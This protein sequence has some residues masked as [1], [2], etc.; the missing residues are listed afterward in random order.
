MQVDIINTTTHVL[1]SFTAIYFL[2]QLDY[3]FE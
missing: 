2:R 1:A 3:N